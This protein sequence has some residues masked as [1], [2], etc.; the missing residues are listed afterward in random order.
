[1]YGVSGSSQP[2]L[3]IP[4]IVIVFLYS[5]FT[6]FQCGD[7]SIASKYL[8]HLSSRQA[9]YTLCSTVCLHNGSCYL[10]WKK[11]CSGTNR[12]YYT[13]RNM[14]CYE[15]GCMMKPNPSR[16]LTE[17]HQIFKS[18]HLCYCR[19]Q[20]TRGGTCYRFIE[21]G[22]N[23]C[24]PF[25]CKPSHYCVNANTGLKCIRTIVTKKIVPTSLLTC[26]FKSIRS[27]SYLPYTD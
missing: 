7:G 23:L 12:C 2:L 22:S 21:K 15:R 13:D 9:S 3:F 16:Y 4:M 6:V 24:K 20:S 14:S 11:C 25:K 1:M 17:R 19:K 10:K 27:V 5:L 18:V 26:R 8:S